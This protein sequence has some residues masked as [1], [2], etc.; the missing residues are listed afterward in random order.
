MS[1]LY[2]AKVLVRGFL[3]LETYVELSPYLCSNYP[4]DNKRWPGAVWMLVRHLWWRPI[5]S[6]A[7]DQFLVFAGYELP[8]GI[9]QPF[10]FNG[11]IFR[12]YVMTY[13]FLCSY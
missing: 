7:L 4:V 2:M 11:Q 6:S 10:T 1:N 8:M 5:N 12:A 9:I 13:V 3:Q